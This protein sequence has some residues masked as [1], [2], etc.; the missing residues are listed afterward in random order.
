MMAVRRS[1]PQATMRLSARACLALVGAFGLAELSSS[2]LRAE[3]RHG[4][5]VF[6]DLKYPADFKHF[7]YVSPDAPKGGKA[8][9]IG[10]AGITTFDSFNSF[11]LKGD[12]AQGMELCFDTLM[13]RAYDE[14]DSVY[15]LVAET[16]DV[17]PD[18]MSV[19]FKMRPEAKFA[20]GSP[21]T[22]DDVVFSFETIK[23]K[24]HPRLAFPLRDVKS[25]EALDLHSVRFTFEGTLVRDLPVRVAGLPILSKA[26][27][28]AR[29]RED[30]ARADPR[31][32]AVQ[33]RAFQGRH[34]RYL[35]SAP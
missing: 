12:A 21:V 16:A 30:D 23:A 35:Y 17:A 18:K 5:S 15:G 19:T 34:I 29:F 26:F 28:D 33:G 4:L 22:A 20:D 13:A 32:G 8:S 2:P 11:I 7:D 27:R 9:Q 25:A 24:G 6:G 1:S 10:S 14:P 3:P 31:I